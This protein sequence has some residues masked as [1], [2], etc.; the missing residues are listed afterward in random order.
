MLWLAHRAPF[1]AHPLLSCP[2]LALHVASLH[3]RPPTLRG[4]GEA[5]QS[6]EQKGSEEDVHFVWSHSLPS[7]PFY[8]LITMRRG[9]SS[10]PPQQHV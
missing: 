10:P 7:G 6:T 9:V 4:S 3:L 5:G 1:P 2:T 8:S